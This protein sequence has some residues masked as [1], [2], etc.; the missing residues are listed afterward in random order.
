MTRKSSVGFVGRYRF[1]T[2]AETTSYLERWGDEI[3]E[4]GAIGEFPLLRSGDGQLI[5]PAEALGVIDRRVCE[6]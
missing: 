4:R 1:L 5:I 3:S 2:V 6:H